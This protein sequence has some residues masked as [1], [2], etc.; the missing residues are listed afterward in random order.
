MLEN[1]GFIMKYPVPGKPRVAYCLT[2][3]GVGVIPIVMEMALWGVSE[4]PTEIKKELTAALKND[5]AGVLSELAKNN[6]EIYEQRKKSRIE[7][8]VPVAND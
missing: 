5:K 1:E 2:E 6:L 3:K 8:G 7:P 4:N